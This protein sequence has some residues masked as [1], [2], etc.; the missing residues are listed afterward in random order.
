M[1]STTLTDLDELTNKVRSKISKIYI[2]EAINSYK[3][4]ANRA[5]LISTWIAV[6]YDVIEKIKELSESG[7]KAALEFITN[8]TNSVE[9]HNIPKLQSIEDSILEKAHRDFSF[10]NEHEYKSLCRLKEDRNLCA[11]PA[12][13]NDEILYQPTPE[14]VRA[15]IVHSIKFLLIHQPVQGKSAIDR[16]ALD[17]KRESFPSELEK[18]YDFLHEKYL[19]RAKDAL[20]INLIKALSK[21]LINKNEANYLGKE[22][23]IIHSLIAISKMYPAIY[24]NVISEYLGKIVDS[25][26]DEELLTILN[27]LKVNSES[28]EWLNLPSKIRLKNVLMGKLSDNTEALEK[29]TLLEDLQIE[30]FGE[31]KEK[32]LKEIDEIFYKKIY[33][34]S[35][36]NSYNEAEQIGYYEI[37]PISKHFKTDHVRKV[38]E[39][40]LK[41]PN[42]QIKYAHGS[43][44]IWIEIFDNT[45]DLLKD[46]ITYWEDLLEELEKLQWT[47]KGNYQRLIERIKEYKFISK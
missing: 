28:W 7:D 41:N 21:I 33:K 8:L 20:V 14:L 34:Y 5:A 30:D 15:Y 24:K 47:T 4:G 31:I 40:F 26:E 3:V 10:L 19:K 9:N 13:T 18:V 37:V 36:V 46:T 42:D 27:L 23:K 25:L 44:E 45:K 17:I 2:L 11:H 1:I 35:R 32:V 12:F 6:N 22:E 43:V 38:I 29:Y 39:A 16:I